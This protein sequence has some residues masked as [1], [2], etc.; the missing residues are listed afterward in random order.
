MHLYDEQPTQDGAANAYANAQGLL[1][2]KKKYSR[3]RLH[4]FMEQTTITR[5]KHSKDQCKYG[6][7]LFNI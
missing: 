3:I 1:K 7:H 5:I 4:S 2:Y 6:D